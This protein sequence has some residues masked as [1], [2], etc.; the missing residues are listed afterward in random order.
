MKKSELKNIV[1]EEIRV[2][3][4]SEEQDMTFKQFLIKLDATVEDAMRAVK[5]ENGSDQEILPTRGDILQNFTLF[6]NYIGSLI[7]RH[8]DNPTKLR[9]LKEKLDMVNKA[10][11]SLNEMDDMAD[12]VLFH[13][14]RMKDEDAR[15][16]LWGAYQD[17]H[18][19]SRAVIKI[20]KATGGSI[21]EAVS[22]LEVEKLDNHV[23]LT[24]KDAIDKIDRK[25]NTSELELL[26]DVVGELKRRDILKEDGEVSEVYSEKQRR[27]ACAQDDPKFDEMCA[28]T[29]ISKK[30]VKEVILKVMKR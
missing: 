12:E 22:R 25:L 23:L 30:K 20:A 16:M 7:K 10:E 5:G 2:A 27:W 1:S 11:V 17:G 18:L 13:I 6:R 24:I 19:S 4:I 3:L 26:S 21:E 8:G 28:D 14:R 15:K 9:F 29:K